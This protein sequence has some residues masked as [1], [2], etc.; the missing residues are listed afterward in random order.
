M[1][2]SAHNRS[3]WEQQF[4][5]Y[6]KALAKL[7]IA[8]EILQPNEEEN[9]ELEVIDV[10]L[11]DGLIRRFEYTFEAAWMLMQ[12]YEYTNSNKTVKGPENAILAGLKSG[13]IKDADGWMAMLKSRSESSLKYAEESTHAIFQKIMESYYLLFL[14]F[15]EKMTGILSGE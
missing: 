7:T 3:D 1:G 5:L 9:L 10:L 8:V 2:N 4:L 6:R 11:K 13:L 12:K 14:N 15:E